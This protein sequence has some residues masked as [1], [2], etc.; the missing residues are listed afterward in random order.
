[1]AANSAA[2]TLGE[3]SKE[4]HHKE[5]GGGVGALKKRR[6]AALKIYGVREGGSVAKQLRCTLKMATGM[7]LEDFRNGIQMPIKG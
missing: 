4:Q 2:G 6:A 7:I 1:M 5:K 3:R